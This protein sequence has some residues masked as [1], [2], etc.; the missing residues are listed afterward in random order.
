MLLSSYRVLL[1]LL[2]LRLDATRQR[3]RPRGHGIVIYR[4]CSDSAWRFWQNFT[5]TPPRST[6]RTLRRFRFE[7]RPTFTRR[8]LV[9]DDDD[10]VIVIIVYRRVRFIT[11]WPDNHVRRTISDVRSANEIWRS[12]SPSRTRISAFNRFSYTYFLL[13][14]LSRRI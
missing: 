1:L 2:L 12:R 11:R 13:I 14:I 4:P 5:T 8:R 9:D 3:R 7:S 6:P 10:D